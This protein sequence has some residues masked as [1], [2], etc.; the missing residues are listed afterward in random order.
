MSTGNTN[1]T[2]E[3]EEQYDI[4]STATKSHD[5]ESLCTKETAPQEG[6]IIDSYIGPQSVKQFLKVLTTAGVELRGLEPVPVEAR[7]HTKYYQIGTLFGGSFISL[8]P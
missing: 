2:H 3:K 1:T 5:D 6:T 4:E 7:T 8:L